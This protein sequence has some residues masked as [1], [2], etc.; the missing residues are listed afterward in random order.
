MMTDEEF[1]NFLHEL[2]SAYGLPPVASS[3]DTVD[4]EDL[5]AEEDHVSF[6][7]SYGGRWQQDD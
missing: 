3:Q 6:S 2:R 7:P 1:R 4:Y 5:S